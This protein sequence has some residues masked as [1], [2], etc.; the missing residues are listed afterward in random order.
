MSGIT[1]VFDIRGHPELSEFAATAPPANGIP[2]AR[3]PDQLLVVH[4]HLEEPECLIEDVLV[5]SARVN[6]RCKFSALAQ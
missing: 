1:V 3:D 4:L 6:V 2:T 5:N